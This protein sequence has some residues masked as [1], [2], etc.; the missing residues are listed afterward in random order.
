ML[1]RAAYQNPWILAELQQHLDRERAPAS[2]H[3]VVAEMIDYA[4]RMNRERGVRLQ[5]IGRHMLGLFHGRP[6][7]RGWRR[8]LS[9]QMHLDSATPALL[10]D[11]LPHPERVDSGLAC[12]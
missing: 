4:G 2:R 5:A 12:A 11:C 6:G 9:Q 10:Q 7:A 3:E 8:G 1:G